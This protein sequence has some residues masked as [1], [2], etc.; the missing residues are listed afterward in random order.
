M[1]ENRDYSLQKNQLGQKYDNS[2]DRVE[3][4]FEV[5]RSSFGKRHIG[6]GGDKCYIFPPRS[7]KSST[8]FWIFV[9]SI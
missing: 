9:L 1:T 2:I 6:S 7:K 5:T 8:G 3:S 4:S